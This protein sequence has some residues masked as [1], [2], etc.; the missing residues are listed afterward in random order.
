LYELSK[1][2]I[3]NNLYIIEPDTIITGAESLENYQR[4]VIEKAFNCKVTNTYGCREVMLIAAECNKHNGLH[5]NID[6]LVVEI[7]NK[8]LYQGGQGEVILTDLSNYAMP[9]IRYKNGD[10]ATV[11][12]RACECGLS[13]PLL[14]EVNGR[15]LDI[16]RL[17]GGKIIPGEFFPHMLK[18]I[19]GIEKYQVVQQKVNKLDIRLV[20]N[21]DYDAFSENYVK[22]TI[23]K[24]F[25]DDINV[26]FDY[27]DD[28]EKTE[29]GK[30][31]VTISNLS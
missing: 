11:D 20:V 30:T 14:K 16:I 31:R 5:T 3:E 21:S 10:L 27:V 8:H 23:S 24:S 22:E 25:D 4:D 17:N 29:S 15:I 18:D 9:L 26:V 2:I 28:I 1:Y 13:F 19:K 6:H 12:E 7:E